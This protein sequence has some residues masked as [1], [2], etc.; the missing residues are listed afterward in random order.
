MIPASD[1]DFATAM[2]RVRSHALPV[3]FAALM[4][5]ELKRNNSDFL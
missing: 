3:W 1:F 4:G 5:R 2:A